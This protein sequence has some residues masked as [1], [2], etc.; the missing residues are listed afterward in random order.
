MNQIIPNEIWFEITKVCNDLSYILVNEQF[1]EFF[2]IRFA[3]LTILEFEKILD[4]QGINGYLRMKYL[5][6]HNNNSIIKYL[7]DHEYVE[8]ELFEYYEY[9]HQAMKMCDAIKLFKES[10]SVYPINNLITAVY[11]ID[12]G[13]KRARISRKIDDLYLDYNESIGASSR[14]TIIQRIDSLS[15]E[16][17]NTRLSIDLLEERLILH[18]FTSGQAHRPPPRQP[19]NVVE[20]GSPGNR[21]LATLIVARPPA[22][23]RPQ[24]HRTVLSFLLPAPGPG[25]RGIGHGAHMRV[26]VGQAGV[27]EPELRPSFPGVTSSRG[28]RLPEAGFSTRELGEPHVSLGKRDRCNRRVLV[29]R[30]N[31]SVAKGWH[32][33]QGASPPR[34]G[35]AKSRDSTSQPD[36]RIGQQARWA[37]YTVGVVGLLTTSRGN[38]PHAEPELL[39]A[40]RPRRASG[41]RR[42]PGYGRL[43]SRHGSRTP[44]R[45]SRAGVAR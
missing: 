30:D 18:G 34:R 42:R 1:Y 40:C 24:P 17:R 15:N 37:C 45:R 33:R 32:R 4:E 3:N 44:H 25:G 10:Y 13:M 7:E 2:K 39:G 23:L 9:S 43:R 19:R 27:R 12:Y 22:P 21:L 35:D 6:Q 31:R 36:R 5:V 41:M 26:A 38:A 16:Q 8:E 28:S 11:K 20:L 14:N 29:S